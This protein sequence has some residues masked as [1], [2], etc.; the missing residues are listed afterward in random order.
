VSEGARWQRAKEIFDEVVTCRIE[1][2]L[3]LLRELCG[4]DAAL[5]AD[6]ESLLT[7]DAARGS[8]LEHSIDGELRGRVIE[9]VATAL[10]RPS[11]T[12]GP[13]ERL[14]VYE[15]TGFLG[16]GGMG[17]VYRARDTTL[18]RYVALKILPDLWLAD[19]GRQAR[20][21]REA[22]VLASLNHPNIASIYGVHESPPSSSGPSPK[23]LILELVEG[24]TLAHRIISDAAPSPPRRGLPID[25]VVRIASQV[26]EAL[27][28]AHERGIV[29]RDL[30]PGNIKI[31]PEGRVKVLDFG[32]ARAAG[33]VGG[34]SEIANSPTMTVAATQAGVLLGTAPYMSPE[35]AR[36]R[37]VDKR[38]D[39][40]AFGCVLYEMLAGV[41]AFAGDEAT[42]VLANVIKTEPEWA[43]LPEGTPTSLRLCVQRCLQ[44]DL[45]QRF[46]DIADVRLA[47]EGAFDLPAPEIEKTERRRHVRIAYA[48]V[49]VAALAIVSALALVAFAPRTVAAPPE[50]RLEI[51]T[52]AAEDPLSLAISPD[53]RS[54]VFQGGQDPPR[55]WLRTLDSTEARPLA[56]TEGGQHPFWSPDSRSV[57][58]NAN[59]LLKRLDLGSGLVRTLASRAPVG[60]SWNND[61]TILIGSGIGP[62]YV[63]SAEGGTPKPATDL[64]PGQVTHR[65]PQFLPDGRRFVLFA[66]GV[67]NERGLYVGSL[68]GGRVQRLSDRESGYRIL[69]PHVLFARQGA[70]LARRASADFTSVQGGFVPVAP[71]VLVHRGL[72][73]SAAFSSSSNG[74]IAYRASA[75]ETQLV[76]LDRTGRAMG[77]L[78]P[79]DDSQL[80]VSHLSHDGRS[81][82]VTRTIAG[83]TNVWLLDS[84]RGVP[85]RLTFGVNDTS[86]VFSPDGSRIAHQA[87][88]NRE[89]TVVWE[90]RADG[91]GGETVLLQ[92]ADDY[93]FDHPRDWSSDGRYI[94]YA[95]ST[96]TTLDLRALPLFGD[97]RPI[98]IARTPFNETAGR[99]SP[100][101]RWVA[102]QSDETGRAEI[103]VQPFPGPGPKFQVS[104]AGGTLPR[105]R[106]DG[107]ELF[108]IAPDRK[109][110]SVPVT[111][112]LDTLA[113]GAPRALFTISTTSFYE[114]SPDGQRFLMT[115]VVSEVSPITVIMNWKP[116]VR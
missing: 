108:Y 1:D 13:G 85:R 56:G 24:E 44:K 50:T 52:P 111:P 17:R 47:I 15:I 87:E 4:D 113:T 25:D 84:E 5:V 53:G 34:G 54:V 28:A 55:L 29:H 8:V 9:A 37:V 104:V 75:G 16:A 116:P 96:T 23:A 89:G 65:W 71:K 19:P 77:T 102:Y 57:G 82:A 109:L 48:G 2:R 62:L 41:P 107:R 27:E 101:G 81:V 69:S 42:D 105:W 32:L 22:R 20:F 18:G 106:R 63:V 76:W 115:A 64:L 40:W 12:L 45:R 51:V 83:N 14:G 6:V 73:G 92:E 95:V 80:L 58:F 36:G 103:H 100:D 114:P 46:H 88:G 112:S 66:L 67:P 3:A 7:A 94:L 33:S 10:D 30:K 99:F 97:R 68:S 38:A 39:I 98:D 93:E 70:L 90:R 21:E 43:A 74:S 26:I 59:G 110:M 86:I 79:A 60:G 35:Q 61:G 11:Q 72:F 49:L 78:G 31:T 91:T